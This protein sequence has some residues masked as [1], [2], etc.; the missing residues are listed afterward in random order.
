MLRPDSRTVCLTPRHLILTSFSR[1]SP[2]RL[3]CSHS[4][5]KHLDCIESILSRS[6]YMADGC[7]SHADLSELEWLSMILSDVN[8]VRTAL[9]HAEYWHHRSQITDDAARVALA[10]QYYK[11]QCLVTP[12]CRL[13]VEIL[14]NIFY[15][16]LDIGHSRTRLMHVCQNWRGI[17]EKMSIAWTSLKLQARTAPGSVQQ[18]LHRA[19]M[20]PL[21]VEIDIGGTEGTIEMLYSVLD[22]AAKSASRW[23]TLTITALPESQDDVPQVNG[24]PPL[25]LPP[26]IQ[27]R[28][29]RIM[30]SVSS[31]LLNSLLQ[32]IGTFAVGCLASMEIHSSPALLN[33]IQP[34]YTPIFGCITTF[35]AQLPKMNQ[36]VDLLPHFNQLEVLKLTN[37]HL[38]IYAPQ[39]LP[40]VHTLHH[41]Y[42][43]AV[44]I[45]WMGGQVF[46]NLETCTILSPPMRTHP[47]MLNV[48]LPACTTFEVGTNDIVPIRKFNVPNVASLVV[49]SNKWSAM[50]GDGQIVH[51]FRAVFETS[52]RPNALHLAIIYQSR[53]LLALLQQLPGLNELRLDLPRSSALGK[54]FF[55]QLLAKPVCEIPWKQLRKIRDSKECKSVICPSLRVLELRYQHWL[56]HSDC[57]DFLAPLFAMSQSRE[58]TVTKLK[59]ELHFVSSQDTWRSF[60]LSSESIIPISTLEIPAFMHSDQ[61]TPIDLPENCFTSASLHLIETQ[62]YE[63]TIYEI[64]VLPFCFTHLQVLRLGAKHTQKLNVLHLF[65]QL[66]Q[67]RLHN[68][69]VPPL[70]LGTDLPLVHTLRALHLESSTLAWMDGQ[71]FSRLLG[72]VVD[73]HGWPES[74][75][76]KVEMPACTHIK[77]IQDNLKVLPLLHSNI[78]LPLLNTWELG[79]ELG[80]VEYDQ[81]GLGALKSIQVKYLELRIAGLFPKL[82]DLLDAKDEVEHLVLRLSAHFGDQKTLTILSVALSPAKWTTKRM[83][84]PNMRVLKLLFESLGGYNRDNVR[85]WCMQV[86]DL[87]R[88]AG[89]PIEKCCI[90]WEKNTWSGPPSQVLATRNGKSRMQE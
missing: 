9:L 63:T 78:Y 82:G 27:L 14:S 29:L 16:A 24:L 42:L 67:L 5:A 26:M 36:R 38:P 45:Q 32:N 86:M 15:I 1:M 39:T 20:H 53:F 49:K 83:P 68:I 77:F 37:V 57:L 3:F 80:G 81:H 73:E 43:R 34:A 33:L 18:S 52:L 47:L 40:L 12:I 21:L 11:L 31:P 84:C 58:R 88:L 87:R 66:K 19:Q 23:E 76:H 56:R 50:R 7:L 69:E 72:F 35:K 22:A 8:R 41:L 71:V 4:K 28:H 65:Q 61:S 85:H 25:D 17:I 46:P 51:L 44:S 48:G 6:W 2:L 54:R 10:Q 64:L 90:W 13:P 74:F 60:E 59:M 55:T 30:P 75:K 70:A 89:C 62:N 79:T